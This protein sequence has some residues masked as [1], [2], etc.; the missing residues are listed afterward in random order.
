MKLD[1]LLRR[2]HSKHQ[3]Y[4]LDIGL[5]TKERK[6]EQVLEQA[7]SSNESSYDSLCKA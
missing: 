7:L 1:I 3:S 2:M 5:A 4:S 6:L